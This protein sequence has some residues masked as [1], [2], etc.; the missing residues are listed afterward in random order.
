MIP[1]GTNIWPGRRPYANYAL[2]G[3]N[4]AVFLASYDPFAYVLWGPAAPIRPWARIM[5]LTPADWRF[6]QPVTYA[7]LHGGLLHI[8]G[9]MFFLYL[10]GNN[11][12]DRLGHPG[13]LCFYIAGAVFSGLGHVLFHSYSH[14]PT[15]GASGAVAAVTGAYLVF[16]PRSL[17]TVLYW[18][19]FLFGTVHIPAIWFI[20]LKMILLDNL[21]VR[22]SPFIAYDAHLAGYAVGIGLS[23]GLLASRLIPTNHLDLWSSIVQWN[24]RRRFRAMVA[25]GYDPFTATRQVQSWPVSVDQA[26]SA[27]ERQAAQ[28][29]ARIYGSI[30]QR[31]LAGAA[32][33]YLELKAL[34]GGQ[35]ISRQAI[36]DIANYLASQGRYVEAAQAY[37]AYLAHYSSSAQ[38]EQVMLMLGLLYSRY[39]N[40]PN[41]ALQWLR[42]AVELLVDPGQKDLCQREILRLGGSPA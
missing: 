31:D 17:I 22:T 30:S 15:I 9:N 12:N 6:W 19:V 28:L 2:I 40:K 23:L 41:D 26:Q 8:L 21:V 20:G 25:D 13:Y 7:F 1:I 34:D 24:R 16:F 38:A 42:R 5:M 39:L 14:V 4:I 29:R 3:M 33:A 37:E 32:S 18:F 10:F 35:V 36:L 27:K 11:V